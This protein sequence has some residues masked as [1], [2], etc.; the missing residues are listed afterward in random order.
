MVFFASLSPSSRKPPKI[1]ISHAKDN[2]ELKLVFFS[3][4]FLM[5]KY[6][7]RTQIYPT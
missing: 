5:V 4:E 6:L 2:I 3:W 7:L 1:R